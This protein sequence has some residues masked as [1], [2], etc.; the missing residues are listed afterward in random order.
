MIGRAVGSL[1]SP[2]CAAWGARQYA[3]ARGERRMG[4]FI[5]RLYFI[6][7]IGCFLLF[8]LEGPAWRRLWAR[9]RPWFAHLLERDYQYGDPLRFVLQFLFLLLLNPWTKPRYR[10]DVAAAWPRWQHWWQVGLP[11]AMRHYWQ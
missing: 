5:S 9:Y 3:Y 6:L 4:P 1:F 10:R 8:R 11:A 2:A 7:A